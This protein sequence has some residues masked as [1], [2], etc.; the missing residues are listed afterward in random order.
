MLKRIAIFSVTLATLLVGP[1]QAV[2]QPSC[3]EL[4][5]TRTYSDATHQVQVGYIYGECTGNGA[6][7]HLVGTF[8]YFQEDEV[9][10]YCGYCG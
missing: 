1:T 6:N 10:G 2:A 7:Y 9:V 8:T 5:L 3:F 4:I